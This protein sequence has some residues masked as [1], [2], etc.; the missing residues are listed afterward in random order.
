MA[1]AGVHGL[2]VFSLNTDNNAAWF[3]GQRYDS[4]PTERDAR[5]MAI[6]CSVLSLLL[7]L[8]WI[9]PTMA[10]QLMFPSISEIW[11]QLAEPAEA[12]FVTLALTLLPN[13]MIGVTIKQQLRRRT[14]WLNSRGHWP[15]HRRFDFGRGFESK[16]RGAIFL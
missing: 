6:L 4:V 15:Q 13:G 16:A 3:I 10:A 11:P 8:L 9:T 12:S 1:R 5:K 2:S 14:R 7:P